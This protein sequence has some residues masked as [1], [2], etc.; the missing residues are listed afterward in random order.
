MSKFLVA[1]GLA[2]SLCAVAA[3]SHAATSAKTL[4]AVTAQSGAQVMKVSC[5]QDAWPTRGQVATLAQTSK[6]EAEPL[7]RRILASGRATCAQGYTHVLVAFGATPGDAN[8]TAPA[9]TA[10]REG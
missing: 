8:V 3:P 1:T 9:C 5:E 10:G 2:L 4:A 7:R 6:D